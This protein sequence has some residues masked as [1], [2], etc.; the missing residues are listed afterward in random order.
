M[1]GSARA[2]AVTL[3]SPTAWANTAALATA[4][5]TAR[6]RTSVFAL[7]RVAS[8]RSQDSDATMTSS[9]AATCSTHDESASKSLNFAVKSI[10]E[11]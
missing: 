9:I 5:F 11:W 10:A 4:S 8:V 7:V 3:P 6:E 1:P 2:I